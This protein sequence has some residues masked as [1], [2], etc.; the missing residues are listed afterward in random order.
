M[1]RSI[2]ESLL[3][4]DVPVRCVRWLAGFASP[5]TLSKE[6]CFIAVHKVF[7]VSF[8]NNFLGTSILS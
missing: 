6:E 2:L 1:G 8:L 7:V 3:K 5:V 4:L